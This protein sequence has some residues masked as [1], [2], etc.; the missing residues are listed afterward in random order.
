[1]PYAHDESTR[2]DIADNRGGLFRLFTTTDPQVLADVRSA[3]PDLPTTWNSVE[4]Y[5][6]PKDREAGTMIRQLWVLGDNGEVLIELTIDDVD[7]A[8]A[9]LTWFREQHEPNGIAD[10]VLGRRLFDIFSATVLRYRA[11][12]SGV[13]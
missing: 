6:P 4:F 13:H 1:M 2:K 10:A 5:G 11:S 7:G 9:M 8:Q 12:G 3:L